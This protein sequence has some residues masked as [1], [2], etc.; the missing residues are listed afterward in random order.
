MTSIKRGDETGHLQKIKGSLF[1][2]IKIITL[3]PFFTN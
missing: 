1:G 3:S 2:F